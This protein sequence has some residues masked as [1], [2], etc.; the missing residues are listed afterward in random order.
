MIISSMNVSD[1]YNYN[2]IN[3]VR[4]E[5]PSIK[6]D[7]VNVQQKEAST[8]SIDYKRPD[9]LPLDQV[10]DFAIGELDTDISLIGKDKELK[11]LDVNQVV[12]DM[13]KDS[14][15]QEYQYFVGNIQT[16]DGMVTR[17]ASNP[18]FQVQ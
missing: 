11:T 8:P 9:T 5:I 13:Q 3:T 4:P 17:C 1:L 6:P 18:D 2:R 10:T 16:D 12:S 14:I 15:L 7:E